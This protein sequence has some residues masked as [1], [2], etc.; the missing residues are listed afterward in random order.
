MLAVLETHPIQY[1]APV[2]RMAMRRV[3]LVGRA[4]VREQCGEQGAA[5]TVERAPFGLV[6][7]QGAVA[8]GNSRA[9]RFA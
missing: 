1:R 9:A 3:M 6:Q 7:P 2:Y 8:G 4:E 5:Y